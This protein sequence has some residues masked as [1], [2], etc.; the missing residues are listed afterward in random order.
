MPP[1]ARAR[2]ARMPTAAFAACVAALGLLGS[3]ASFAQASVARIGF[4]N[5]GPANRN[6]E[7]I[8]AFRAGLREL[9]YVEGRNVVVDYRWADGK[10]D[11]LPGLVGELL[12][13]KPGVIVSTGGLPTILAVKAAT[14][15]VPIVFITGDPIAEGIVPSLARPGSNLTGLA[16]LAEEVDL[17]RLELLRE[18]LPKARTI[19]VIWN[20]AQRFSDR[21][22]KSFTAAAQGMGLSIRAWEA[23]DARELDEALNAI[24]MAKADALVVL[25]D[26]VLGFARVRIVDFALKARLPGIYFWREFAQIGGLLSYGTNLAATYRRSATYVDKILKGA[27]PGEIPVELPT[28]FELVV[29]LNTAKALGITIPTSLL[30]RADVVIQ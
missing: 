22:L 6:E 16:V 18:A 14:T 17:K 12:A 20:P 2:F 25:P 28:T 19:A 8:S 5:V 1:P 4:V 21:T 15:A 26:P 3:P 9:G 13:L 24:A 29:N 7:N 27:K 30:S 11:R 23:R 10:V